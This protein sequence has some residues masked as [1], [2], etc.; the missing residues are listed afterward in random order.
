M[1]L[2]VNTR[3]CFIVKFIHP[4]PHKPFG[5]HSF[6]VSKDFIFNEHRSLLVPPN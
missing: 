5:F 6:H 1:T 4:F 3:T 2:N